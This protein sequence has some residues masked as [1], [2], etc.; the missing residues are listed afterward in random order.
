DISPV[1]NGTQSA[2]DFTRQ[3][4]SERLPAAIARHATEPWVSGVYRIAIENTGVWTIDLTSRP[5][6]VSETRA[7]VPE[8]SVSLSTPAFVTLAHEPERVA[9]EF[10]VTGRL[11]TE[12]NL[13]RVSVLFRLFDCLT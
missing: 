9:N 2:L 7:L 5:P 12:G 10:A 4:F 1:T 8:L 3:L 11:R 13:Q 6:Q